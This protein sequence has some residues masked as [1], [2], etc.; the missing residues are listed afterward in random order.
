MSGGG[1]PIKK[2][3]LTACLDYPIQTYIGTGITLW[4][5]RKYQTR[6]AYC[7][8]FGKF[9]FERLNAQGKL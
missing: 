1:F 5:M 2:W 3:A 8:N 6:S 7:W 9:E 4:L